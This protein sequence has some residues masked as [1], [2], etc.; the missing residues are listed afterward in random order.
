V[1][2]EYG[3]N[4]LDEDFYLNYGNDVKIKGKCVYF[5]RI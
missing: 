2:N 3:R 5:L 1:K 4:N